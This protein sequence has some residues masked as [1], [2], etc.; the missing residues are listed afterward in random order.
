[1]S[2]D[3][4]QRAPIAIWNATAGVWETT[5]SLLCGH[6][7][8]FSETWPTSGMTRGGQAF[9]L[10]TLAPHMGDSESSSSP[11]PLLQ[12]PMAAEGTKPSNTMGVA[13]R[14]ATGQVFLT[15]QIVS[16]MGLDPS[17]E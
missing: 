1:M 17:E 13:R 4:S 8:L 10:P 11:I 5:E 16:L 9:A 2:A 3:S 7:A 14:E 15:N 12:T 6:S